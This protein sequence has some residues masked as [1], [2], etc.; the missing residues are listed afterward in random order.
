MQSSMIGMAD[1]EQS[2][3]VLTS[4]EI[5]AYIYIYTYTHERVPE[6]TN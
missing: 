1:G 5:Y 6:L 4:V 3:D 2:I